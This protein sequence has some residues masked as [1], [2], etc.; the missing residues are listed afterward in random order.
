MA[1][2]Y[3]V[4]SADLTSVADAIRN[5]AGISSSISFPTGFISSITNIQTG[6]EIKTCNVRFI[7][8]NQAFA[9]DTCLYTKHENGVSTLANYDVGH[10]TFDFT[11]EN[12]VCGTTVYFPTEMWSAMIVPRIKG[13]GIFSGD[14]DCPIMALDTNT[15]ISWCIIISVDAPAEVTVEYV[16][17]EY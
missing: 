2:K 4:N 7:S 10:E 11:L 8:Y 14:S 3:L 9:Q 1:D 17:Y 16:E 6:A 12:V 13:N 15:D 5:K